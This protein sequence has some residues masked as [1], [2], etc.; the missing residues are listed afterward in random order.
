MAQFVIQGGTPLHGDIR[1]SGAKNAASKMLIASLLT[2]EEC[3]FENFPRIGDTNITRELCE[4]IGSRIVV[5][6]SRL[7]I[8]T[9]TLS[10]TTV[11]ALSRR[12]RIPV[13][14]LGALL[15]RAGEAEVPF[16]GGDKIG[17]RPIDIHIQA[18]TQ[19]GAT[20]TTGEQSYRATV[21][22]RLRGANITF[23]YPS[24]GA[25]ENTIFA[26][27]FALGRTVIR[28]AAIEPEILDLIKLLQNMG[29]IIELGTDRRIMIE[30]VKHLR[31]AHHT[32]LPDRN[33]AV[34]FACLAIATKG[35][36]IV[37]G[38]VQD[39]L[40]TFLNTVRRIGA[41]YEVLHDGIRFWCPG[42]LRAAHIETD[43]HPG[44]MTDW[45]QPL[46][47][48]LTQAKGRSVVH[49]T[50]YEDRF[51]YAE[52]LN[53]MGARIKVGTECLGDISCRF[54]DKICSHTALVEGPT[55]LHGTELRVRDIRAGIAHVIAAL[56]AHGT[57]TIDN[58][59]ELDRGYERVDERLRYIGAQIKRVSEN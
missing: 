56:T 22:G 28:N 41:E 25:T 30:G 52:D 53:S 57:S 47:V 35:D 31:G 17:P 44:F 15:G 29:A 5:E 4:A 3:V 18:L 16:V 46:V 34:S 27:V 32:I 50:V 6:G 59:E 39:H 23:P 7:R 12:N 51:G 19:L 48:A 42:S 21:S 26:S 14:A 38:A 1:L 11:G 9:P 8:V 33:E 2:D 49:E 13:L 58:I 55:E 54:K 10:T 36:V 20:I 43:T 45:Q 24:V 40:V 37:K